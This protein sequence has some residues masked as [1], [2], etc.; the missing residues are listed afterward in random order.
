M[1][2]EGFHLFL[3]D[4]CRTHLNSCGLP[5]GASETVWPAFYL[6]SISPDI[7]FYDVPTFTL[8]RFGNSLHALLDRNGL[9]PV[10]RRVRNFP[11]GLSRDS[12]AWILGVIAHFTA[13]AFWHPVVDELATSLGY[14]GRRSLT[15]LD[16][17]RFIESELEAFWLPQCGK[18]AG[19][20][21]DFLKM[22]ERG[23]RLIA[24]A[25]RLYREFL[26]TTGLDPVPTEDRI[27]HCY[28]SQN[29]LL[30]LFANPVLGKQRDRL[31]SV[32]AG[33]YL[34]SL[35]VPDR[36]V[37]SVHLSGA[38]ADLNP[39]SQEFMRKG[40]TFLNGRL[41]GFA[42]QLAQYLPS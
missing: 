9:S 31:M 21:I 16:C 6:G 1:P 19:W 38:P 11:G 12:A 7:F 41:S 14:C 42:A 5:A 30:R 22:M 2:K 4:Q 23:G 37:L 35:V 34:A 28:R 20:Y 39:F 3:A 25:S 40:L 18:P 32:R 10:E 26:L 33:R 29:R 36:P 15:P 24:R 13:D 27:A 17:H 8:G